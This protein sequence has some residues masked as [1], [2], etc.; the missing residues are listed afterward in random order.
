MFKRL[1][2]WPAALV[3]LAVLIA[4]GATAAQLDPD[5]TVQRFHQ[6]LVEVMR[7]AKPLGYEGRY[8]YLEPA[9][10]AAYNLPVMAESVAGSYWGQMTADQRRSLTE[11]FSR[12]TIATYATR[13]DGYSGEAFA[14]DEVVQGLQGTMLVR[15]RL[16]KPQAEAIRLDYLMRPDET[17]WRIVD[18]FLKGAFSEL[19]TKRAEYTS[20]IRRD[21]IPALLGLID[22]KVDS[23]A[24]D[25]RAA[26]GAG[27]N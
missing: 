24:A 2:P 11:A 1:F 17:G 21:G 10:R 18:V 6:A 14:T 15:T 23:I 19:A 3:A 4:P 5:V 27:A 7:Q 26:S 12:M 22:R 8:R 25:A 16:M 20:I 13:F 9:I